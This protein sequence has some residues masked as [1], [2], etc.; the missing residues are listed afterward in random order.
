MPFTSVETGFVRI[1]PNE[2]A[3]PNSAMFTGDV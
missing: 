3:V 1:K 2:D